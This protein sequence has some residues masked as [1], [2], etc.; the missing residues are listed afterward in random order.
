M[1]SSVTSAIRAAG[2]H[3]TRS[4]GPRSFEMAMRLLLIFALLIAS[5]FM[6]GAAST[7]A[8]A[9]EAQHQSHAM[10]GHHHDRA[11]D[12]DSGKTHA[13]AHVCPGCALVAQPLLAEVASDPRALP[14]M[15]PNAASLQAFH[16]NPIPPP[17]RK[18]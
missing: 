6:G 18:S 11:P 8:H 16:S 14:Q 12:Q 4:L 13:V 10:E 9:Q 5:A 15:P 2:A 7:E 17:P 3:G 1:N